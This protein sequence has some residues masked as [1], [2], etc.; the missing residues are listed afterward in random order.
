MISKFGF[1]I[2]RKFSTPVSSYPKASL[3]SI[4]EVTERVFGVLKN[5]KYLP[6]NV[7]LKSHFVQDFHLDS[8]VR[9][10]IVLNL[11]NE[12]CIPMNNIG[13]NILS[14]ADAIAFIANHPKA[15]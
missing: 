15:R 5:V 9:R 6:T 12:F 1:I 8:L 2:L 3:L 11:S 13:D 14:P 7:Q 10:Q 4:E